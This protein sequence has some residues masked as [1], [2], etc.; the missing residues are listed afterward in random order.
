V[1]GKVP[2]IGFIDMVRKP[3]P[4]VLLLDGGVLP[5]LGKNRLELLGLL[6]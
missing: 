1:G 4:L 2:V 5:V 6:L 3:L